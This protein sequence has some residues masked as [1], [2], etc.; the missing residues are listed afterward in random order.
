[1]LEP[2]PSLAYNFFFKFMILFSRCLVSHFVTFL[3]QGNLEFSPFYMTILRAV[4][5]VKYQ[6][7]MYY[8]VLF[9]LSCIQ[10]FT[11]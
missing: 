10:H 5:L 4:V 11:A 6:S 9:Q 1:M 7:S 8:I 2:P 3:L